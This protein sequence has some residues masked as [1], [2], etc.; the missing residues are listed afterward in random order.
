MP[1]VFA[2]GH[3]R[4]GTTLLFSWDCGTM[5]RRVG[6][7]RRD[8]MKATMVIVCGHGG[9]LDRYRE[10]VERRGWSL[11]HFEQRIPQGF[12]HSAGE[13]DLVVV[14]LD[15]VSHALRDQINALVAGAAKVIYLRS[16]SVSALRAAVEGEHAA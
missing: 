6:L 2:A 13:V 7:T 1:D 8:S 3:A 16:S 11:K 4:A 10:V 14:M 12:R 9:M 5:A 15:K